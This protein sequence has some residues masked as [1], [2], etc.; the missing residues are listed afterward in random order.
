MDFSSIL[1]KKKNLPMGAKRELFWSLVIEPDWIQAGV[2]EV[3]DNAVKVVSMGPP[4]AWKTDDELISTTDSALSAAI[5]DLPE[6][7]PEPKKTVFG[8]GSAWVSSGEIRKEYLDKLKSLCSKLTLKPVGFVVLSEAIAH[9]IKKEEGAPLSAILIGIGS[10]NLEVSVYRLGELV[11]TKVVARSVSVADDV[12]EGLSRFVGGDPLPSRLVL[13]NGKEG[14]LEEIKNALTKVDWNNYEKMNFLHTP[15]IEMFPPSNKVMAVSLAGASEMG[16]VKGVSRQEKQVEAGGLPP[17]EVENV[18]TPRP[19]VSAGDVGFVIGKD[20]SLE[21]K[22]EIKDI[23]Q[24]APQPIQPPQVPMVEERKV[25]PIQKE[26]FLAKLTQRTIGRFSSF[27]DNLGGGIGG[28]SRKKKIVVVI[29]LFFALSISLFL[30]WWFLPK[31]TVTVYVSPKKLEEKIDITIDTTVSASDVSKNLLSGETL[32]TLQ[33]GEKTTSTTGS[34]TIGDKAKGTV[35]IRNGTS[36]GIQLD[37]GTVLFSNNDLEFS[38]VESASVSAALSPSDPGKTTVEVEASSFGSEYNL[39]QGESFK[40]GNYPKADVDGE[41]ISDFTGGS[42]SQISAVS[43]DD[44]EVLYDE[45]E[46]ELLQKASSELEDKLGS[47]DFLVIGAETNEVESQSYSASVGDEADT[48]KL[49]LELNVKGLSVKKTELFD[50][51]NEAIKDDIPDGYVLRENQ[52]EFE[53]TL[54]DEDDGVYELEV[55]MTVNLLPTVDA[56]EVAEKIAGKKPSLA[57]NF[58][59]SIPGYS[60]A[61]IRLKP[62]LPGSLRTLPHVVKRIEVEVAAER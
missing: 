32:S 5:N 37:I 60:R 12:F 1:P 26:P 9:H 29:S 34:R 24:P 41:S 27:L 7:A 35:E 25:Q 17:S 31:A 57:E 14:E 56:D 53:F 2:W 19:G 50:L 55:D 54:E 58:L 23:P 30:A 61:S 51:V 28:V 10:E 52:A 45:L 59:L 33:E 6:D 40:V 46:Q 49:S 42:S 15:K 18:V 38:L 44:Q 39:A 22:A 48:L 36:S 20:V 8:V 3:V 4:S 13:Y 11:G 16:E 43:E 62:S 47:D 21:S